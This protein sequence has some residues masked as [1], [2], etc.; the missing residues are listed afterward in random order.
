M[1]AKLIKLATDKKVLAGLALTAIVVTTLVVRR[2]NP[3]LNV[4]VNI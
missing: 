3:M 4:D 2:N 1:K